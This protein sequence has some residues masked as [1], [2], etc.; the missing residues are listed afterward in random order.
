MLCHTIGWRQLLRLASRRSGSP[1][2][3]HPGTLPSTRGRA[4]DQPRHPQPKTPDAH[5]PS[6]CRPSCQDSAWLQWLHSTFVR[7]YSTTRSTAQ[8]CSTMR[9]EHIRAHERERLSRVCKLEVIGSIPI[10]SIV[11]CTTSFA[12]LA[13]LALYDH[14]A[15]AGLVRGPAEVALESHAAARTVRRLG[16]TAFALEALTEFQSAPDMIRAESRS[17]LRALVTI[18]FTAS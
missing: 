16:R 2:A 18:A 1:P 13:M 15:A 14:S 11:I 5:G 6:G 3:N 12:E 9:A 10:R 7:V 8:N 17:H 4:V